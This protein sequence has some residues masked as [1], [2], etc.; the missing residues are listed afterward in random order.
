MFRACYCRRRRAVVLLQQQHGVLRVLSILERVVAAA[1][2][3]STFVRASH[4]RRRADAHQH[5]DVD[6]SRRYFHVRSAV[7]LFTRSDRFF[8]A[9]VR[10]A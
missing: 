7:G 8:Q 6:R 1:E 5:N 4:R 2:G 3:D 10:S 9:V